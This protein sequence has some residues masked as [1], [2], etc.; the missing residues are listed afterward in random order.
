MI[1]VA[2]LG[3]LLEPSE[4]AGQSSPA[5]CE[6]NSALALRMLKTRSLPRLG[7]AF[8]AAPGLLIGLNPACLLGYMAFG[9]LYGLR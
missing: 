1:V 7:L 5:T 2:C 6:H 9:V 4:A 8:S 3:L